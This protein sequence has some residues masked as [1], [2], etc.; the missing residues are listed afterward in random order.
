MQINTNYFDFRNELTSKNN[1]DYCSY[2]GWSGLQVVRFSMSKSTKINSIQLN[3]TFSH[4]KEKEKIFI[5]TKGN[6]KFKS[7]DLETD[8]I[9]FDAIDS[10]SEDINYEFNALKDSSIFMISSCKAM[11]SKGKCIHF[12]FKKDVEAKNLW[13]GQIISRPY[14]GKELT[15]VLFDLKPGFKF[16]DKGHANEQ[17]TWL[18]EGEMDFYS[19]NTKKLLKTDLG[20]SIGPYHVHGGISA[21]ALG[22]DAFF[23]KRVEEKYKKDQNK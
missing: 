11:T 19:N 13:G 10:V 15:V 14:E 22:F 5:C 6:I 21:G 20:V 8:L 4:L 3:E 2:T 12:N 7:D 23:P 17:I 18:T 1:L 16:E 9:E